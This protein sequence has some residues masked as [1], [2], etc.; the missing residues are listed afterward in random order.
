MPTKELLSVRRSIHQ[1]QAL[2]GQEH[3]K[4]MLLC[5]DSVCSIKLPSNHDSPA[6]TLESTIPTEWLKKITPRLISNK[7]LLEKAT[8]G[9]TI[10]TL[11]LRIIEYYFDFFNNNPNYL[12]RNNPDSILNRQI[13]D[14]L[15]FGEEFIHKRLDKLGKFILEENN[16]SPSTTIIHDSFRAV[17]SIAHLTDNVSIKKDAVNFILN[18]FKNIVNNKIVNLTQDNLD[19]IHHFLNIV[20]FLEEI[21]ELGNDSQLNTAKNILIDM[22]MS[23]SDEVAMTALSELNKYSRIDRKQEIANEIFSAAFNPNPDK[24]NLDCSSI[25]FQNLKFETEPDVLLKNI[26]SIYQ[27]ENERPGI[28]KTLFEEFGI[29][30][31]TRYPERILIDQYDE[32]IKQK[33]EIIKNK[34]PYGIVINPQFDRYGVFAD[35]KEMYESLYKQLEQNKYRL[36]IYEVNTIKEFTRTFYKSHRNWGKISFAMLGG[37]GGENSLT[38][39][40]NPEEKL[41]QDYIKEKIAKT[42]RLTFTEYPVII[43]NSCVGGRLGA[44]GQEISKL[45]TTVIASPETIMAIRQIIA[46]FFPNRIDFNIDYINKK[47]DIVDAQTFQNG[48]LLK[49]DPKK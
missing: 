26:R 22:L 42:I 6:N 28:T 45:N 18:N 27:L 14:F 5:K 11:P 49:K 30:H 17:S 48:Y 16:P 37:H 25:Q 31:F 3:N 15:I 33:N 34:S 24:I 35:E 46:K 36:R 39:S 19:E 10:E 41:Y 38:F 2:K 23:K 20:R 13:A 32:F 43:L 9:D 29:M 21:I 47:G 8:D 44:I 40:D 7:K 1:K 12:P 4:L